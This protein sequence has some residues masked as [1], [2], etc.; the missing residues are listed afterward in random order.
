MIRTLE[1]FVRNEYP[2][3][4]LQASGGGRALAP[5]TAVGEFRTSTLQPGTMSQLRDSF[6]AD[7]V[8]VVVATPPATTVVRKGAESSDSMADVPKRRPLVGALAVGIVVL[9]IVAIVA[10]IVG[11]HPAVIVISAIFAAILGGIEGA[12]IFGGSRFAGEKAWD[13]QNL[14]DEEIEIAAVY[15][16]SESRA[17]EACKAFAAAGATTIRIVGENGAWHLPNLY[18]TSE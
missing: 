8:S 18:T 10:L 4:Q 14:P 16:T 15:A 9:L 3:H 5:F 12:I 2:N 6:D 11:A 13:Q 7:R 1:D 17:L